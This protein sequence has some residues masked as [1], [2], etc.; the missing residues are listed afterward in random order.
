[1]KLL[2]IWF[3]I[4]YL[5]RCWTLL[6]IWL[7][8]MWASPLNNKRT[9]RNLVKM[10]NG[11]L[12]AVRSRFQYCTY[13]MLQHV[14]RWSPIMAR[15][16]LPCAAGVEMAVLSVER[17]IL[18]PQLQESWRKTILI[19][20][21]AMQT[22]SCHWRGHQTLAWAK[23]HSFTDSKQINCGLLQLLRKPKTD[24]GAT[25]LSTHS[26]ALLA[27]IWSINFRTATILEGL[28]SYMVTF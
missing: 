7:H 2:I 6:F 24:Q 5:L 15:A 22:R 9:G 4:A 20:L 19:P 16:S 25:I 26:V 1:M 12:Y 8:M 11:L 28:T 21:D 10:E 3:Q 17:R 18:P 13:R 23:Q 14:A 27:F